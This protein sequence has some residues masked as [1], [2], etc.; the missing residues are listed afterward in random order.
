MGEIVKFL[1]CINE[2]LK[3]LSCRLISGS[4]HFSLIPPHHSLLSGVEQHQGLIHPTQYDLRPLIL[5]LHANELVQW[6]VE[7]LEVIQR[8]LAKI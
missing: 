8:W 4:E 5:I 2:I 6:V 3:N 1:L 7:F